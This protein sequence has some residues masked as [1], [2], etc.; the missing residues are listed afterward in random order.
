MKRIL[1]SMLSLSLLFATSCAHTGRGTAVGTGTGAAL[2]AGLGAIVGNQSGHPGAGV[3]IGAAFGALAGGAVGD[4]LDRKQAENDVLRENL[5]KQEA[6]IA[7]NR[8]LLDELRRRGADVRTTDRGVV[9]SLPDVLFEF[10]SADLTYEADQTVR[11]IAEVIGS[12]P[13]R[14]IAVEGHTDNIGS[15]EYNSHLSERRARSVSRQLVRE[16]V[17]SK[18]VSVRG[19]GEGRPIATNNTKAGRARNRRVEII[20]EN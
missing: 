20:V 11:D 1:F 10:D 13:N 4:S 9:V 12:V 17:P 15:F 16:G 18:K 8:R 7:E 2:G 14:T 6:Q 19:Y 3:A 5:T